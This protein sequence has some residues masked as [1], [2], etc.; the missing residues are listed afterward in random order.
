M[1]SIHIGSKEDTSAENQMSDSNVNKRRSDETLALRDELDFEEAERESG[2][3]EGEA[4]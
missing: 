2:E 3:E 4:G 1:E